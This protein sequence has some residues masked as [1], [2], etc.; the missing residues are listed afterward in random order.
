M[1]GLSATYQAR[2]EGVAL[3]SAFVEEISACLLE[4]G[5]AES[6]VGEFVFGLLDQELAGVAA[7]PWSAG[8]ESVSNRAWGVR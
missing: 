8:L 7:Y 5:L 6:R 1:S 4:A 3:L 2:W